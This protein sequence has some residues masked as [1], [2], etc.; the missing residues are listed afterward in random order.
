MLI[1]TF[2][3]AVESARSMKAQKRRGRPATNSSRQV[4]EALLKAAE[5]SVEAKAFRDVTVK[6]V[7][8]LANVNPSMINYYF[9]GKQGLFTALIEFLFLDWEEKIA[10]LIEEMPALGC[11]P[12]H[13]F[14]ELVNQCYYLHAPTIRLLRHEL[15]DQDSCIQAAYRERLASR[16]TRA[17]TRFIQ[18]AG[19]LGYYRKDIDLRFAS[20]S[21]ACLAI[22]PTALESSDMEAAYHVRLDELR[23]PQWLQNLEDNI[24]RLFAV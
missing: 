2:A 18:R 16:T 3:D 22:H 19:E 10:A 7:G 11:S 8:A 17:I 21:L 9:N 13:K 15:T 20:L 4:V 6:E 14:V 1:V 24:E 23:S 5:E 12:T